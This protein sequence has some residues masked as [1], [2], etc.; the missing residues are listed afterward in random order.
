MFDGSWHL[1]CSIWAIIRG[2][3]AGSTVSR[4]SLVSVSVC[5]AGRRAL[6]QVCAAKR[7]TTVVAAPLRTST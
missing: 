2:E 6:L 4:G 5:P 3:R 1:R 7:A